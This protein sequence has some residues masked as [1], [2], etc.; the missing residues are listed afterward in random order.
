MNLQERGQLGSSALNRHT[1][2]S[3]SAVAQS[4]RSEVFCDRQPDRHACRSPRSE[5]SL[6]SREHTL[7]VR[8][9][10][11]RQVRRAPLQGSVVAASA[12]LGIWVNPSANRA[13]SSNLP[14]ERISLLL[15]QRRP[16]FQSRFRR[17]ADPITLISPLLEETVP[18]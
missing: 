7:F 5:I 16:S 15:F 6:Q 10:A 1:W 11:E 8:L 2:H 9:A 13:S 4:A 18:M 14:T 3:P 12:M 17:R